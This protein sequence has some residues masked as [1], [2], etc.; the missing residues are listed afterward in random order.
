MNET[1]ALLIFDAGLF[2]VLILMLSYHIRHLKTDRKKTDSIRQELEE[3]REKTNKFH[4][5]VE[6]IRRMTKG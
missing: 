4:V 5:S 1:Q 6:E 3:E 2:I